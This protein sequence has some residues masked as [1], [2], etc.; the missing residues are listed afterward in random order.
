ME[1]LQTKF[2][3]KLDKKAKTGSGFDPN[4]GLP[5]DQRDMLM[6]EILGNGSAVLRSIDDGGESWATLRYNS[7]GA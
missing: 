4:M 7:H 6:I 5:L 2:Q 3:G 1:W